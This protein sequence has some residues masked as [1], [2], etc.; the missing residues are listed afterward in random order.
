MGTPALELQLTR[1][2]SITDAEAV[3]SYLK[4]HTRL[5]LLLVQAADE[6]EQRFPN[7]E[8]EL[9]VFHDPEIEGADELFVY[10]KT[11]LPVNEALAKLDAFDDEWFLEIDQQSGHVFNVNL[12]FA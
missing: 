11:S 1:R 6:L 12:R 8:L 4:A 2:F 9:D 3:E 7:S 5:P 10:V